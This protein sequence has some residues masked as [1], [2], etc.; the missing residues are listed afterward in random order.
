MLKETLGGR[1]RGRGGRGR[2]RG[3]GFYGEPREGKNID[4]ILGAPTE[5]EAA[6]SAQPAE[7]KPSE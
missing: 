4:L 3:R 5:P 7:A 1:G 2:G 6:A